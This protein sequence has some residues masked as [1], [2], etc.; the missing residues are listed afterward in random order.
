MNKS[1]QKKIIK[2]IERLCEKQYRKGFQHGFYACDEKKITKK[3]VDK[4][5]QDG[6]IDNYS[7]VVNPLIG[8]SEVP[9]E[10]LSVEMKMADMDELYR[11][12][13]NI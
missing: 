6:M 11:F 2:Q 8:Y 12:L 4:F 10:R 7:K 1:L 9:L 5:R 13:N 3:Q